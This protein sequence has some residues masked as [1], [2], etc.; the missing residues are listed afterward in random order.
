VFLMLFPAD[1]GTSAAG[2][3]FF[4][5]DFSSAGWFIHA[6]LNQGTRFV[7]VR[8][9]P[10]PARDAT[11]P[12][13]DQ[14]W[15]LAVGSGQGA[16]A[17]MCSYDDAGGGGG[18]GVSQRNLIAMYGTRVQ[19]AD[20]PPASG[21]AGAPSIAPWVPITPNTGTPW[22]YANTV[23]ARPTYAGTVRTSVAGGPPA[24][25][26]VFVM[27]TDQLYVVEVQL[28]GDPLV[29]GSWGVQ[30]FAV[31]GHLQV[32]PSLGTLGRLDPGG[33]SAFD[34]VIGTSGGVLVLRRT[35]SGYAVAQSLGVLQ[36]P[37]G[38]GRL[39]AGSPGDVV[40]VVTDL[41]FGGGTTTEIVPLLNR[42]DGTGTVK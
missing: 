35:A 7:D 12:T 9:P 34:V 17:I 39:S 40:G 20:A 30:A 36:F 33:T 18:G 32:E 19:S 3:D 6:I 16:L 38:I 8:S 2:Q 14:C 4:S 29:A 15:P 23:P 10:V 24:G 1:L 21:G 42:Q 31:P 27:R 11:H 25:T 22:R 37:M 28:S 26:A 5:I 41:G 13:P